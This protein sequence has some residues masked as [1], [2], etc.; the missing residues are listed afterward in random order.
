VRVKLV[1]SFARIH[2]ANLVN[3]GIVPMTFVNPDDYDRISQDDR[4]VIKG[5]KKALESGA[6]SIN[7]TL[8]DGRTIGARLD[9]SQRDREILVAGSLLAWVRSRI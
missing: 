3:F 5:L 4:L 1:K 8:P 7:V 2:K 6:E 9:L